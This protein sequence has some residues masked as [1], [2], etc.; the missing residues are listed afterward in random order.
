MPSTDSPAQPARPAM[1][2]MDVSVIIVSYNTREITLRCLE[3]LNAGLG[4]LQAETIVIDNASSDGSVQAIAERFPRVSRVPREHNLGFGAANNVGLER[5]RGRYVLLLNSDAF[6][7]PDTVGRLVDYLDKRPGVGVVAPR[8]LNEDG[9]LQRSCF[10]YPSPMRAWLENLGI[11]RLFR[12]GSPLGDYRD[13][14]HDRTGPVDWAIGACLLVRRE[15]IDRAGGFD[16]RFFMYAEETDWQKRIRDAGWDICLLAD[17]QA[18]HLGGASGASDRVRVNEQF[19]RSID[20]Y[21]AKHYGWA[22][23][24]LFRAAM[25]VGAVARLPLWAAACVLR[26][27]RRAKAVGRVRM[28]AWLIGRQLWRRPRLQRS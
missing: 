25:V 22:G 26:P 5:A 1:R 9:T 10:R 13:W 7:E 8:L 20:L 18:T 28:Y 3:D 4:G 19:F 27:N 24:V 16:E 23:L 6:V 15:A 17:A 14:A 21:Q 2:P 12:P 11:A